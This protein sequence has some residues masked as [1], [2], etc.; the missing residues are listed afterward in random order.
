M[1][2]KLSD[3]GDD[4]EKLSDFIVT[5]NNAV[6]DVLSAL[7]QAPAEQV[8]ASLPEIRKRAQRSRH[9]LQTMQA[10]FAKLVEQ[11]RARGNGQAVG[12]PQ[13]HVHVHLHLNTETGALSSRVER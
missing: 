4:F 11:I 5:G 2:D 10:D 13:V 12:V 6:A 9:V 8:E 3:F 7:E 1:A